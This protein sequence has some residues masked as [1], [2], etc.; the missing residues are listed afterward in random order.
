ML[1]LVVQNWFCK[2][3]NVFQRRSNEQPL[4]QTSAPGGWAGSW[5]SCSRRQAPTVTPLCHGNSGFCFTF[6]CPAFYHSLSF[7]FSFWQAEVRRQ[8]WVSQIVKFV[9]ERPS[10]GCE[11]LHS[12][13][14]CWGA[15]SACHVW[16]ISCIWYRWI[17]GG[18][19]SAKKS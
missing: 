15:I 16:S 12:F 10:A 7:T 5:A 1:L 17:S 13:C 9:Y 19:I 2:K 18:G 8:T 3:Y 4:R 14:Y 6:T 11:L